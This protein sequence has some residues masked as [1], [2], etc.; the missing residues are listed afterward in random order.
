VINEWKTGFFW[1]RK[2]L[3]AIIERIPAPKGD[4]NAPLQ[5]IATAQFIIR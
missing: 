5:N 2:H 3:K 1:W 4:V